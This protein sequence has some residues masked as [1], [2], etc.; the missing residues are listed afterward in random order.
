[1]LLVRL[2]KFLDLDEATQR[3][4]AEYL[5][6]RNFVER[7]HTAENKVLSDH[8]PFSS[9]MV[10]AVAAP[11]S[12]EHYENMKRMAQ[13]VVDCIGKAVFNKE[14]IKCFRGV[15]SEENYIFRD[16]NELKSFSVLSE[17]RKLKD[18][19]S[20]CPVQCERLTYLEKVW[21]VK[22]NFKGTYVEDY[23]TLTSSKT[24]FKDNYNTTVFRQDEFWRGATPLERFDRQPLP[25]FKLWE[26]V[27][28]LHYMGYEE[29]RDFPSGPWDE[30]PGIFLP[31][32]VLNMCFRELPTPSQEDMKSVAFLA[33]VSLDEASTY[34]STMHKKL[35]DQREEDLQRESWKLHPLYQES[36]ESL[37][38]IC[39]ESGLLT[40]GKKHELVRRIAG[41]ETR[42]KDLVKLDEA[43]LY[44]GD[45]E[46]IPSSSAG[47]MR[48]SVAQLRL[49]L[50]THRVLEVGT[51]EE[52]VTRVGLLKAGH[53]DAA[54]SRERLCILHIIEVAQQISKAQYEL[55]MRAV[56]RRRKFG[57]VQKNT[58]H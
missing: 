46:S 33:W 49:I 40:T 32:K 30:S 1:M 54:F 56:R 51:K 28:E 47:L 42:E 19:T 9:K 3:S 17:E 23:N 22:S 25:D 53:S 5:S 21:C 55:N 14:P 35:Q 10:H 38:K 45:I 41:N 31:E 12:K 11:G 48:L 50:R 6:K 4:F 43:E 39:S 20:Y 13:D 27:G 34:F 18:Q 44:D 26:A 52:L 16:E 58:I 37:L 29:R 36:R 2:L 7:V 8:G 24:A 15:G 57:H